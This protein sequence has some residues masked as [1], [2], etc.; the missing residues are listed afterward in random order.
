VLTLREIRPGKGEL[1]AHP[2][3]TLTV[4]Q[5]VVP[6]G[7]GIE[8]FGTSRLAAGSDSVFTV[9]KLRVDA[10]TPESSPVEDQFA[11]AQFQDLTDEQKLSAPS[12]RR[13]ESGRRLGSRG[14]AFDTTTLVPAA[15]EY[16]TAILD[17]PDEP[18]R[19]VG[20]ATMDAPTLLL[21][22][23]AGPAALAATR[24]TGEQRFAAAGIE[25]GMV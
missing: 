8:R 1:L 16:E 11:P 13:H 9:T 15:L 12:F 5:R 3:G 19:E 20:A 10:T 6:F 17:D 22:A 23:T 2:F 21:R 4:S 25:L 18:V 14:T 24:T 7:V